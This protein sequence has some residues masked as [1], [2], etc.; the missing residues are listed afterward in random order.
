MDPPQSTASVCSNND[1]FRTL[2]P[3][4]AVDLVPCGDLGPTAE[5][6]TLRRP[7][8]RRSWG[9]HDG[10]TFYDE[11]AEPNQYNY[12]LLGSRVINFPRT[13]GLAAVNAESVTTFPVAV[14]SNTDLIKVRA[15][16]VGTTKDGVST[17]I[18][19][20]LKPNPDRYGGQDWHRAWNVDVTTRTRS[21][22][23]PDDLDGRGASDGGTYQSLEQLVAAVFDIV[24]EASPYASYDQIT[25][26][27][28]ALT[29]DPE[30]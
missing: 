23:Y 14:I 10:M 20:T 2:S 26:M 4:P 25:S 16:Q 1:R 21:R 11:D 15:V 29:L 28:L 22:N 3:Q 17:S 27:D 9:H 19:V 30:E 8:Q 5:P 12:P 6:G 13:P 24:S 18:N 7:A